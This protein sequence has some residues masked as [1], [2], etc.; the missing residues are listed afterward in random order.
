ML[1]TTVFSTFP[2]TLNSEHLNTCILLLEG[3]SMYYMKINI[4]N[5]SGCG[6]GYNTCFVQS[7]IF[8]YDFVNTEYRNVFTKM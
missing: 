3:P 7:A 4:F 8:L 2:V 6:C 5:W 1:V